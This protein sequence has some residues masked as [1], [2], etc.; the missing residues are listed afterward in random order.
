MSDQIRFARVKDAWTYTPVGGTEVL[1]VTQ[2]VILNVLGVL[3]GPEVIVIRDADVANNTKYSITIKRGVIT[4]VEV[5][6][7]D[8]NCTEWTEVLQ[9]WVSNVLEVTIVPVVD[10]RFVIGTV[11]LST[12]EEKLI[13][14]PDNR[15][16]SVRS[17]TQQDITR[18]DPAPV[19]A[20]MTSLLDALKS[21]SGL[22][23]DNKNIKD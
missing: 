22:H 17:V 1:P 7:V 4:K 12:I 20:G 19:H 6:F 23:Y 18:A 21:T 8:G 15:T 11:M 5:G 3:G 13:A 2:D 16:F 10:D 9:F 14:Q